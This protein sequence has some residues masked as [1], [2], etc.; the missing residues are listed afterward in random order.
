MN[1]FPRWAYFGRLLQSAVR[2]SHPQQSF[3]SFITKAPLAVRVIWAKMDLIP[4]DVRGMTQLDKDK[5]FKEITVPSVQGNILQAPPL[6]VVFIKLLSLFSVTNTNIK[7]AMKVFKKV[8][9]FQLLPMHS[10]LTFK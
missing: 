9:N 4:K 7:P 3:Q 6:P 8:C 2:R 10:P 5:F 1:L